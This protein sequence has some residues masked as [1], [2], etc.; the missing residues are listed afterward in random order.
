MKKTFSL[1][2]LGIAAMLASCSQEEMLQGATS[3]K[4]MTTI[5]ATVSDGMKTRAIPA[6]DDELAAIQRCKLVVYAEGATT[7]PV[8]EQT[9]TEQSN[10]SFTFT[11]DLDEGNYDFYCWADDGTSYNLDN[12]LGSITVATTDNKPGIAHEGKILAQKSGEPITIPLQHAVAKVVLQTTADITADKAASVTVQ[13]HTGYSV[14]DEKVTA[15]TSSITETKAIATTGATETNPAEVLL[16]YVLVDKD[17]EPQASVTV[18]YGGGDEIEIA[19]VPIKADCRTIL[20]GDLT[21]LAFP[22]TNVT[23][24]LD[25]IWDGDEVE[26]IVF[27]VTSKSSDD[28]LQYLNNTVGNNTGMTVR[29]SGTLTEEHFTKALRE[30]LSDHEDAD[31]TLDLS[32]TKNTI[33]PT[34]AFSYTDWD[35]SQT[36]TWDSKGLSSIILPE[37]LTTIERGAFYG[38]SN[39][40]S[41]DLT[42]VTNIGRY[43]FYDCSSL[44]DITFPAGDF[45]IQGCVF[46]GTAW[47]EQFSEFAIPSTCIFADDYGW[48]LLEDSHIVSVTIPED[49][50]GSY[51]NLLRKM[52]SLESVTIEGDITSIGEACFHLSKKLT[53]LDLSACTQVPAIE[54]Y[55]FGGVGNE[56]DVTQITVYVKDADME[57]KFEA[58][59]SPWIQRGFTKEKIQVKP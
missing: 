6:S 11:L 13:T 26:N 24:T 38:C 31:L 19:N 35:G 42:H 55:A 4:S 48:G 37:C 1:W 22:E 12:G 14:F 25:Q 53:T 8:A 23:A 17:E 44:S 43:A 40:K 52:E 41:V 10:N 28:L 39:L 2:M 50:K 45:N 33:I 54:N 15:S 20:K 32:Q 36:R 30:F 56:M 29:L 58:E 59:G 51:V 57:A 34:S 21:A 16:F 46:T 18:A 5:T 49:Y 47:L 27:N 9:V 3:H 7:N